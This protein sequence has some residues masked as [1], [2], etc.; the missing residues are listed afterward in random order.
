MQRDSQQFERVVSHVNRRRVLAGVS[1]V[2]F[3]GA[4]VATLTPDARA[5]ASVDV[6]GLE[7]PDA[8][9]TAKQV[10][11]EVRVSL[12]YNYDAGTAPVRALGFTLS[13]D[14]TI[15]G[16]D[17]FVT[18]RTTLENTTELT[19]LVT[20]SSEWSSSDFSPKVAESVTREITVS[21]TFDVLDGNEQSI[22]SDTA[23]T[24]AD[25]TVS[26]PQ[27]SKL[28]AEV[29]GSGEIVDASE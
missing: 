12:A 21:V 3:A 28:I 27:E 19:G 6:D 11:P 14:G 29:G 17:K 24:T 20:D 23:S 9:F 13:V 1:G 16:E 18:D 8:E 26:H 4:G 5:S 22:V 10:E 7:I 15:V 2:A 25:V